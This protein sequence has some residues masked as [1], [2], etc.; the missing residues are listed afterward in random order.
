MYPFKLLAIVAIYLSSVHFLWKPEFSS[1][2]VIAGQ[3]LWIAIVSYS[4]SFLGALQVPAFILIM[5]YVGISILYYLR[6]TE[7]SSTFVQKLCKLMDKTEFEQ[8]MNELTAKKQ[9]LH[10]EVEDISL[11]ET[12]DSVETI[13]T[14]E[15]EQNLSNYY[16]KMLFYACV[17]TFLYRNVWV[18]LLAAIPIILHLLYTLGNF[19]GFSNF[20]YQK[21]NSIYLTIKV[22]L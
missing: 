21:I 13:E 1:R 22:N 20:I 14:K 4:C 17:A 19:T 15:E 8:S 2:F 12:L 5:L 9:S 6:T 11:S 3:S 18:F 10:S 7:E 16:F